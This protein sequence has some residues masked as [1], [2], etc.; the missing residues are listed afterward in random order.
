MVARL[1]L[2]EATQSANRDMKLQADPRE[3]EGPRKAFI[4][5]KPPK[6]ALKDLD[7]SND[8]PGPFL[9]S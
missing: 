3:P 5:Q 8:V 9:G 2:K 4:E 7:A 6:V 1:G